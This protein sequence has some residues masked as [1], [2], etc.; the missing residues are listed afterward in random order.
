[1]LVEIL[2]FY[3]V[4]SASIFP[5]F[6]FRAIKPE[7]RVAVG[8]CINIF[9]FAT[10]RVTIYIYNGRPSPRE[11]LLRKVSV[12]PSGPNNNNNNN[13]IVLPRQFFP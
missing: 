13:N 3:S 2:I 6:F 5:R 12:V 4:L 7:V 11:N 10:N 1:V 8:F 9:R